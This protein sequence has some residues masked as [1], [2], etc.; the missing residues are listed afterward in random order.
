MTSALIDPATACAE[1]DL[2]AFAANLRAI[3]AH[4]RR[5]RPERPAELMVVVK[6]D[7]YGHGLLACARAARADGV[8]WLGVATPG[9]AS[10]LRA[11]GDTGRLLAWL[12]GRDEDLADAVAAEVDLGVH[13][14]EQLHR[15]AATAERAGR[16][17][18]LHLKIDTG[19]S[20]NGCRPELWPEL[21]AAARSAEQAGHVRVVAIWSHFACADVPG[22]PSVAVQ[23]DAFAEA[24]RVARAAGLEPELRHLANS[25]ATLI[26]PESHY[27]LVRVGIASYGIDPAPG[28][29]ASAG[30][31]LTPVMTL[32]AQLAQVKRLQPGDGVSYGHT[33]TAAES[34]TVGVVPLGYADGIP[35]LAGNRAE[36]QCAD[37][38]AAI[39]GV[40]CMDQF[41]VDLGPDSGAA[42]G[43]P[44][45]LFGRP[46]RARPTA[47]DWAT[48]CGT[49]GYEIVTRI[50]VRV[51]RIHLRS[52]PSR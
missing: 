52:D 29:A 38:R 30:V 37:A 7:A 12:Y 41:V 48:A 35:R 32:R 43:D 34:T 46:G 19:L 49:I 2:D 24:D 11:D 22:D 50:G 40:V 36:V 5:S 39:R 14:V 31:E 16:V 15:L 1:I 4:L 20:R 23:L 45:V 25:P 21:C 8:T 6:A 27:D 17:A 13:G 9:E 51:P 44:V 28:L 42:V 3:R 10:A 18:R 47:A 33:W 26:V